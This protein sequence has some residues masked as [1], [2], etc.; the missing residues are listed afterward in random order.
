MRMVERGATV[1]LAEQ[2][3]ELVDRTRGQAH[4]LQ[5]GV[6]TWTGTTGR[7]SGTP[8]VVEAVLG[9]RA[10]TTPGPTGTKPGSTQSHTE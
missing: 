9:E 3:L 4:L 10:G 8:E 7:L 2:N 5:H 6:V 1:L